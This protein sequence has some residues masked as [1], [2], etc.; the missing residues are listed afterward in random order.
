MPINTVLLKFSEYIEER[1]F[2]KKRKKLLETDG[3]EI[4]C[5]K[6]GVE[7]VGLIFVKEERRS[8]SKSSSP[9]QDQVQEDSLE[10]I[11]EIYSLIRQGRS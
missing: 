11:Y 8:R 10:G 9:V 7:D 2:Q 6:P 5:V 3:L 1:G 4:V